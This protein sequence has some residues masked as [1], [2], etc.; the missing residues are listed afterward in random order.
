MTP[1][2]T[3]GPWPA[4]LLFC[5]VLAFGLMPESAALADEAPAEP[6][7][8][9]TGQYRAPVPKSLTGARVVSTAQAKALWESGQALFVDVLPRPPKPKGLPEGSIWRD[10]VR[11]DIPASKWLP[12]VG[13]GRLHPTM[14]DYFRSHLKAMTGGDAG[15]ALVFYCVDR[16]WMSWNAAKRAMEFGYSNV[17]WYPEGTDGW[18][19]G[20][21]PLERRFPEK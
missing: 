12:N 10:K 8:Y 15:K 16:C 9:R 20:D 4:M 21:L 3:R 5:I 2:F 1:S 18:A 13:F 17:I 14:E 11:F 19:A 7:G 6:P